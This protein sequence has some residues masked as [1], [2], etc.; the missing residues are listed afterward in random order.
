MEARDLVKQL[1]EAALKGDI[2]ELQSIAPD[3]SPEGL[4]SVKDGNG[5][6][7]LHFAA[8]GGQV[9]MAEYLLDKEGILANSRDDQG[10]SPGVY[11]S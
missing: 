8:Q 3:V 1:F 4:G 6:N 2:P 9:S 7:A 5:R 10:A 11:G